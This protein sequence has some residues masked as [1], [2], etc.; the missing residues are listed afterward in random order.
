MAVNLQNVGEKIHSYTN[1]LYY[2]TQNVSY[3]EMQDHASPCSTAGI[4]IPRLGTVKRYA[5]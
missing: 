1:D 5:R 3:L 2:L 4:S